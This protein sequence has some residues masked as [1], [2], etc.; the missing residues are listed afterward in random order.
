MDKNT[1]FEAAVGGGIAFLIIWVL[2][3]L[4]RRGLQPK[5][6]ENRRMHRFP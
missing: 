5:F 2:E 3:W 4:E 6:R 1:A